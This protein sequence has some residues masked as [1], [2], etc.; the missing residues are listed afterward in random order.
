MK[1][2]LIIQTAFIG[3]AVLATALLEKI[4]TCHPECEI[5]LMVRKGNE[6]LFSNHPFLHQVIIWDKK[7]T[8]YI[9]LFKLLLQIRKSRYSIV[10]NAQRF[11]ATGLITAFSGAK[12]TV[13]FDKN[14]LSFLFKKKIKHII[15]T[16]YSTVHEIERNQ[17]LISSFTDELSCLPKLYPSAKDNST[18]KALKERPYICIAPSSVW[19]TKQFPK[20]KWISFLDVLPS[21]LIVYIIGAKSDWQFCEKI[22]SRSSNRLVIN[23]AGD[24]SFLQSASLMKDAVMNF[25]NDSA[26]LHFATAVNAPVT[27]IYC[28]TIPEFGFGPLGKNSKVVQAEEKLSCKPCGLHGLKECPEKHFNCAYL[29]KNEQLLVSLEDEH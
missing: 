6:S 12:L 5:D 8:K 17:L 2:I 1:K 20:R 23:L 22:L 24:L 27:A 19:F 9:N 26:P 13:G 28:S 7:G 21:N 11:M 4:H 10:V 29:I 18:T 15:S 14:P 16:N 3:D 25:V